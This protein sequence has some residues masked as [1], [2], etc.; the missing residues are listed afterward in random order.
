MVLSLWPNSECQA[1]D[2][3]SLQ[4]SGLL[5]QQLQAEGLARV[6]QERMHLS[7]QS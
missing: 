3:F 2:M 5:Q 6:S 4:K 7:R 1:Y